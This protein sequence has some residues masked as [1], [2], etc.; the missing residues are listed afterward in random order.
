M[1][2]LLLLEKCS[3]QVLFVVHQKKKAGR[4]F[5]VNKYNTVT[6][7]TRNIDVLK[8]F[9]RILQSLRKYIKFSFNNKTRRYQQVDINLSDRTMNIYSSS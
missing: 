4:L 5:S 8:E 7:L 2:N 1:N 6:K 9:S 3:R